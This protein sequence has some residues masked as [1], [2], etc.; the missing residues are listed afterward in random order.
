MR[1]LVTGVTG[2]VGSAAVRRFAGIGDIIAAD[3]GVLDLSKPREIATRL[4]DLRPDVIV[5]PAA[6]TAVDRAED[7]RELA[8]L[9]NADGPAALARWAAD[10][11]VPLVHL[12]TDYVFDGSGEAPWR[13]DDETGPLGVYGASKLSGEQAVRSAG[14]P[15]LIA[16]TSWVYA[17]TGTNFLRTMARLAREREELR[18]VDDQVG[19]PT[20]AAFI[21]DALARIIESHRE[22]LAGGFARAQGLVHLA[23]GG[24]TSWC[25]FAR[26]IVNGLKR[27]DVRV[28]TERVV[29]IAS[30]DYPTAAVRPLNSRLDLSRL[31]ETLDVEPTPWTTLLDAELDQLVTDETFRAESRS[32]GV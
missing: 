19:A 15:H 7:E 2:Q 12:S 24:A 9:V 26:E 23:A 10:R 11:A 25:G 3:R 18:V 21:A 13:E 30:A 32:Q 8:F 5:N 4:D 16:R 31:C 28:A 14:G 17:S 1:I 22:D 29:P 27:R 6:Y 20:S